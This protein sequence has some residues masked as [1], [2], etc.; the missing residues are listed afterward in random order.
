MYGRALTGLMVGGLLTA[1]VP[2]EVGVGYAPYGATASYYYTGAYPYDYYY[3][4]RPYG[5][6]Y[7]RPYGYYG[8][9]YYYRGH[10]YYYG[11]P[12]GRHY[13]GRP[14]YGRPPGYRR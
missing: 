8:G 9:R 11:R 12:Y 6:Y 1:C 4:G 2:A 7:G 13:Y 5:Y 10:P 3:Y 14:Y